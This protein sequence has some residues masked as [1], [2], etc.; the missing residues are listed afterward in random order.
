MCLWNKYLLGY[1]RLKG[2]G[3]PCDHLYDTF[4]VMN[5]EL[6]IFS[7]LDSMNLIYSSKDGSLC[8]LSFGTKKF[9]MSYNHALVTCNCSR[10]PQ[11]L[12]CLALS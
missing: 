3:V 2:G 7:T 12:R 6:Q 8:V 11:N 4:V 5:Q 10:V 9:C 1:A